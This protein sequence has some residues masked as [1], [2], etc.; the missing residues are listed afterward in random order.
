MALG[1]FIFRFAILSVYLGRVFWFAKGKRITPI[2][3]WVDNITLYDVHCHPN[4]K[5]EYE[6]VFSELK[7]DSL[8]LAA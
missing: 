6:V 1:S 7:L 8:E 2:V 4:G 3:L 5:R